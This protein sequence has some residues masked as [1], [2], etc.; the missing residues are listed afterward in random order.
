MMKRVNFFISKGFYDESNKRISIGGVQT[1]IY[2]LAQLVMELGYKPVVYE[3]NNE[4]KTS[5]FSYDG[6]LIKQIS[7]TSKHYFQKCFDAVYNSDAV[8]KDDIFIISTDQLTIRAK[9]DNVIA[10][11]HGIAFDEPIPGVKGRIIKALKCYRNVQRAEM[12]ENL[13]CVDYNFYN[14][15]RTLSTIKDDRRFVVI[16]NYTQGCIPKEELDLK[17]FTTKRTKILFARRF[18]DYRGTLIFSEAIDKIMEEC[19]DVSVTF[20]GDGPLKGYLEQKYKGNKRVALTS[21]S[22]KDS[23]A[24]HKKYDVAVIPTIFSEGTSLSLCEAMAAGCYCIASHVGGL[25]NIIED[26]YNGVLVAPNS[27]SIYLAL[28]QALTRDL[29]TYK[30]ICVNGYE[31]AKHG[32]SKELWKSKWKFFL[33]SILDMV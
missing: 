22:A 25:T 7:C 2:D 23:L 20:A 30:D 26:Q 33:K 15:Y 8:G 5:S 16:P 3:M 11:N 29:N 18:Y 14:W 17:L 31:T 13:V 27:E 10:I 24:F 9:H 32:F 19:P 6:I 28:K 1:Y 21:Y 4:G 12:V